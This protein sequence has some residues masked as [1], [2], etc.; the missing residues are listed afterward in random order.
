VGKARTVITGVLLAA[1]VA[2]CSSHPGAST[3]SAP[4][5][6]VGQKSYSAGFKAGESI[7]LPNE[8]ATLMQSN[9]AASAR[10]K[11][12]STEIRSQWISGCEAGIIQAEISSGDSG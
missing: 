2:G 6:A 10:Q 8:T 9:C 7:S 12:P 4:Q 3:S 11:M 1:A 5:S